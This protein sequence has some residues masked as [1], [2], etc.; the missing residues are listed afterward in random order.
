MNVIEI[1]LTSSQATGKTVIVKKLLEALSATEIKT[2]GGVSSEG[3]IL[4]TSCRVDIH[5]LDTILLIDEVT[6]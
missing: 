6:L 1:E 3:G 5:G 4:K 2:S